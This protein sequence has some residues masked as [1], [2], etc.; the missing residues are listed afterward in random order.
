MIGSLL[1]G[2]D[3]CLA[4]REQNTHLHGCILSTFIMIS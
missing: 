3:Y 2:A 1:T 4:N